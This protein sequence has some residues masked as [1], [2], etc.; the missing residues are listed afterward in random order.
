LRSQAHRIIRRAGLKPWERVFQNLRSSRETELVEDFPVHVV[1][2]W[3]GNNPDV[4]KMHYLQTRE[5]RFRR[6][7]VLGQDVD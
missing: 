4:A 3:I 5:E 7:E 6:A 2:D 1:T